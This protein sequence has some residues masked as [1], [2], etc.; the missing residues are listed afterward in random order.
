MTSTLAPVKWQRN[1]SKVPAEIREKLNSAPGTDFIAGVVKTM[2][3]E[4]IANG[5]FKHLGMGVV[6]GEVIH[7]AR[8]CP[9]ANM[10]RYSR[11]NREGWEVVHKDLPMVTKTFD[12][13]VP[14][15]GDWSNGSHTVSVDRQVYQRSYVNSPDLEIV[16][17]KLRQRG[18]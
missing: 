11:R 13:D 15:Y 6:D 2:N 12:F 5:Q 1:L 4:A 9:H 10:G 3:L 16:V 17:D 14:N 7:A 8:V 18:D